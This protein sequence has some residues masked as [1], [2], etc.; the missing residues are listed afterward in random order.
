MSQDKSLLDKMNDY[1]SSFTMSVFLLGKP[2]RDFDKYLTVIQSNS[3]KDILFGFIVDNM[4]TRDM[5]SDALDANN[6]ENNIIYTSSIEQFML[7]LGISPDLFW[8]EDTGF[9]VFKNGCPHIITNNVFDV[10]D[11]TIFLTV[12]S[13]DDE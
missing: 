3:N 4:A 13:A 5:L 11:R 6:I 10:L 2:V 8:K 9:L 12:G 1:T 7:E